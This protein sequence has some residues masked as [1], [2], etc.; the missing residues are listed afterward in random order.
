MGF[1]RWSLACVLLAFA[2]AGCGGSDP[3]GLDPVASAADRTLDKQTGRFQRILGGRVAWMVPVDSGSFSVR[4]EAMAV[5]M[6]CCPGPG[7]A[8]T[9]LEFLMLYPVGYA[10]YE[11]LD[12]FVHPTVKRWLKVDLQRTL[13]KQLAS[14]EPE[15]RV[16]ITHSPVEALALLRG[17]KHAKKLGAETINGVRTAHYRVT[18]DVQEAFAKANPKERTVLRLARLQ[19]G[20]AA[21]G[22]IDV[23]V[24]DDGLVRRMRQKLGVD[25]TMTTTL[26][27]LGV[28]VHIEAPPPDETVDAH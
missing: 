10:G 22:H 12:P 16:G 3:S 27:H 17:S 1:G 19:D 6:S 24:G 11:Q 20:N 4:D 14:L 9:V 26:S 28:R 25:Q 21:P 2:A 8:P 18:V 13:T 15:F 5:T 23:W 7:D